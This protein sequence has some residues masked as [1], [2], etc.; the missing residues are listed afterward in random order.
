M[1]S[2]CFTLLCGAKCSLFHCCSL[3]FTVV[4]CV[5]CRKWKEKQQICQIICYCNM[6]LICVDYICTHENGSINNNNRWNDGRKQTND[7][8]SNWSVRISLKFIDVFF[9]CQSVS[10]QSVI[11]DLTEIVGFSADWYQI[12][13]KRIYREKEIKIWESILCV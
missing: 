11:G 12:G 9:F 13:K 10:H 2:E 4:H 1:F 6:I 3:L 5:Q 8:N 7:T